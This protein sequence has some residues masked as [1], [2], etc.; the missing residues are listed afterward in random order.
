MCSHANP[1]GNITSRATGGGR[2]GRF[3]LKINKQGGV[4]VLFNS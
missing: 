2:G 1:I 3:C 4:G